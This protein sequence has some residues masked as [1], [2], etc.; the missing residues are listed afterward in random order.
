[1]VGSGGGPAVGERP[2]GSDEVLVEVLACL[3]Q[4]QRLMESGR[5]PMTDTIVIERV[6]EDA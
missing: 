3:R 4:I 6:R 1:M 5:S 2:P